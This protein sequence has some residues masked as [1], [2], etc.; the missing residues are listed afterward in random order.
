MN[1][2]A[3]QKRIHEGKLSSR[4]PIAERTMSEFRS[5]L[6]HARNEELSVHPIEQKSRVEE[7]KSTED[8]ESAEDAEAHRPEY[9]ASPIPGHGIRSWGIGTW[10]RG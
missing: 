1:S 3:L 8:P 4:G 10:L 5:S 9:S 6:S 7:S 2:Q